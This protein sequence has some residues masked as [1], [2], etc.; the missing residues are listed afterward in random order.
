MCLDNIEILRMMAYPSLYASA[1]DGL[2][3]NPSKMFTGMRTLKMPEREQS[4]PQL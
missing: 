1:L 4:G 3:E 2:V